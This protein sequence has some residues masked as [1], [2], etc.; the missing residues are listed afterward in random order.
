MFRDFESPD[1]PEF[2]DIPDWL[3]PLFA[4]RPPAEMLR[5]PL[6][7][8]LAALH[9]LSVALQFG[10]LAMSLIL[11]DGSNL[12]LATITIFVLWVNH[13]LINFS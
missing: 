9:G 12:I 7:A 5:E 2:P 4:E 13:R 3:S 6:P 10:A 11:A 1:I 8:A